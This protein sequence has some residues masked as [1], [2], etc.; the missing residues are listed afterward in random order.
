MKFRVIKVIL[1]AFI[2]IICWP[3]ETY[4]IGILSIL[5]ILSN[6]TEVFHARDFYEKSFKSRRDRWRYYWENW[7]KDEVIKE[8]K[9]WKD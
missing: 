5:L 9:S 4:R 7:N 3:L 2:V 6:L 1:Y 8:L